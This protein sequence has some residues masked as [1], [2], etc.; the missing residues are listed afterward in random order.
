M[1]DWWSSWSNVQEGQPF[2]QGR[3]CTNV[4]RPW[5]E[6]QVPR[7]QDCGHIKCQISGTV[8]WSIMHTPLQVANNTCAELY[9]KLAI[10]RVAFSVR[11]QGTKCDI[12][13]GVVLPLLFHQLT[14]FLF[15]VTYAAWSVDSSNKNQSKEMRGNRGNHQGVFPSMN[16]NVSNSNPFNIHSTSINQIVFKFLP[17][18]RS[19]IPTALEIH[20]QPIRAA[21]IRRPY[22]NPPL[23]AL[24]DVGLDAKLLDI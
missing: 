13:K 9:T 14:R 4:S 3:T 24:L 21:R 15:E 10:F 17:K 23:R 12:V 20:L 19:K 7:K 6:Y 16:G 1:F 11:H 2:R 8:K 5:P 18:S 22:P